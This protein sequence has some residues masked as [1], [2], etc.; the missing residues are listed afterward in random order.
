M[1]QQVAAQP[2]LNEHDQLNQ[3]FQHIGALA[4]NTSYRIEVLKKELT[5][6]YDNMFLI[7]QKAK[8]LP[9]PEVVE[10]PHD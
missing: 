6:M 7:E 3:Q 10:V 5:A 9:K 1:E 4:L 2:K 8:A